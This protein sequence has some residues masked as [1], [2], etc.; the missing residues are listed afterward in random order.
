MLPGKKTDKHDTSKD[1]ENRPKREVVEGHTNN[2]KTPES[3]HRE[4]TFY[5]TF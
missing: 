4:E 3:Y 2:E 1:Q 5:E